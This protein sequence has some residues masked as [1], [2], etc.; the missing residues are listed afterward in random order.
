MFSFQYWWG[1]NYIVSIIKP[2]QDCKMC[3]YP[4]YLHIT[5]S[6]CILHV[7]RWYLNT[8]HFVAFDKTETYYQIVKKKKNYWFWN[9]KMVML[10]CQ[11]YKYIHVYILRCVNIICVLKIHTL[12]YGSTD[13]ANIL[14]LFTLK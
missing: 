5:V 13:K 4:S 2:I 6:I 3:C 9:A 10:V 12:E 1:G 14:H 11:I 7:T 8:F